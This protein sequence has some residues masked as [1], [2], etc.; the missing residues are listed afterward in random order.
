MQDTVKKNVKKR[1]RQYG[2]EEI[3]IL[4]QANVCIRRISFASQSDIY[5]SKSRRMYPDASLSQSIYGNAY[6]NLIAI[7]HGWICQTR[8][9]TRAENYYTRALTLLSQLIAR[10]YADVVISARRASEC[11][12]TTARD[13]FLKWTFSS[14]M[15]TAMELFK[16]P[17]HFVDLKK[18]YN[19]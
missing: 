5:Q 12:W 8:P 10:V 11:T 13:H 6:F 2:W 7:K 19:Y 9:S 15:Q 3:K 1:Y 14:I 17:F 18:R 4:I 16:K